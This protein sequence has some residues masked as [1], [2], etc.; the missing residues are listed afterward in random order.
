MIKKN[1]TKS[2]SIQTEIK[3]EKPKNESV[4]PQRIFDYVPDMRED[5]KKIVRF[6]SENGG[7]VFESELRKKFL[8]P[9][10][11]MWRAVKR[12]ERLGVI[13]INK[14]DMQNLVI[15]KKD[16]EEEEWNIFLFSCF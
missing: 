14:K 8:Q 5:D 11:T 13:E 3:E 6:I 4:D 7:Q 9:R 2:S 10:T 1:K 12:L 15:L 16:L